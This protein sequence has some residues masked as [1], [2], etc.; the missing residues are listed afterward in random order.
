MESIKEHHIL[1]VNDPKRVTVQH[2]LTNAHCARAQETVGANRVVH[3]PGT[4]SFH[5][6]GSSKPH[7]VI[8]FPYESCSCAAV[9]HCYHRTAV[10]M[11]LGI[12]H[13]AAN[14]SLNSAALLKH[15]QRGVR[16]KT[17]RKQPKRSEVDRGNQT[18]ALNNAS[19]STV[20]TI[21]ASSQHDEP[22][23]HV[24]ST[25]PETGEVDQSAGDVDVGQQQAECEV[26]SK[27][28]AVEYEHS[29][30]I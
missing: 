23:P 15:K 22:E 26:E 16:R 6:Q 7:V 12:P 20:A 13:S 1:S 30:P 24:L 18:S 9:S 11:M 21:I 14:L 8:L 27:N 29:T 10:K 19:G 3:V 28:I 2:G 5:V 4:S 17:G 25:I